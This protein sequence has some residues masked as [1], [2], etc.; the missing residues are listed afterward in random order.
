MSAMCS[1]YDQISDRKC[2]YYADHGGKHNFARLDHDSALERDLRRELDEMTRIR[3]EAVR[4]DAESLRM[5]RSARDRADR[6][7][8]ALETIRD[9]FQNDSAAHGDVRYGFCHGVALAVLDTE[10]S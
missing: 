5:Y 3:D 9:G 4:S 7:R 10:P 1:V 8:R 6:Y 2:C